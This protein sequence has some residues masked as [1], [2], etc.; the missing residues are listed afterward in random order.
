MGLEVTAALIHWLYWLLEGEV[1]AT[2]EYTMGLTYAEVTLE[3][4]FRKRQLKTRAL[5][6]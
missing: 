3:I 6:K 1:P 4:T 5:A 2:E